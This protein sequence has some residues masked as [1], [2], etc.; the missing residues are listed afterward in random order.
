MVPH[1]EDPDWPRDAPE[2]QMLVYL[3]AQFL[4][5]NHRIVIYAWPLHCQGDYPHPRQNHDSDW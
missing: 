4:A 1:H 2:I 3:Y 5:M